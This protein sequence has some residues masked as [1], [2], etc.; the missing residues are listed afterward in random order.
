M[1]IDGN[2]RLGQLHVVVDEVRKRK[3]GMCNKWS[4]KYSA[5]RDMHVGNVYNKRFVMD[6]CIK[7]HLITY[8]WKKGSRAVSDS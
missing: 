4:V 5:E 8:I 1:F 2:V 7:A 3:I 6:R